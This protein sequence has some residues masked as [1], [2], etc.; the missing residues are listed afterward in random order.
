MITAF[1]AGRWFIS[2][3][4]TEAQFSLLFKALAF[5]PVAGT[6]TS[7]ILKICSDQPPKELDERRREKMRDVQDKRITALWFRTALVIILSV[8]A[9]VC[10]ALLDG[11][12]F[13]NASG[14]LQGIG[15]ALIVVG[16]VLAVATFIESYHATAL[17]RRM[18]RELERRKRKLEMMHRFEEAGAASK[19]SHTI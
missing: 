17:A 1:C 12:V 9:A 15:T 16:I 8:S 5:L 3:W 4:L 13:P 19:R 18:V 6:L 10:C 14:T 11:S 7:T 2:E